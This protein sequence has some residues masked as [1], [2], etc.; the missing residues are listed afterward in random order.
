MHCV[1]QG[2]ILLTKLI[3]SEIMNPLFWKNLKN[4][5]PDFLVQLAG[6]IFE[7]IQD[8]LIIKKFENSVV[9]SWKLKIRLEFQKIIWLFLL[10][11]LPPFFFSIR[12]SPGLFPVLGLLE[13]NMTPTLDAALLSS[14]RAVA[15]L[16][17]TSDVESDV[18]PGWEE[19]VRCWWESSLQFRLRHVS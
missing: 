5:W 7:K 17:R 13:R 8:F 15:D 19:E 10:D 3:N 16:G 6:Q 14:S 4:F 2:L 12:P 9:N 1:S 18:S 11:R